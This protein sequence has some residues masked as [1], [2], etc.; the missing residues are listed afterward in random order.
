[1]LDP[2]DAVVAGTTESDV[3]RL[4]TLIRRRGLSDE[5][6]R[7]LATR[8]LAGFDPREAQAWL[9]AGIVFPEDAVV[10]PRADLRPHGGGVRRGR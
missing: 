2:L 4:E 3:L 7:S 10:L 5:D 8:W 9:A 6:P 1:M